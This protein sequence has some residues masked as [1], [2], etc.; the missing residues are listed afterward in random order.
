MLRASSV[1]IA[2]SP[3]I[4]GR[5]VSS[6]SV[7]WE[8]G[9]V[10]GRNSLD[11]L[12]LSI[13]NYLFRIGDSNWQQ[14]GLTVSQS[15]L[16]GCRH[17]SE[18]FCIT[19]PLSRNEIPPSNV[20]QPTHEQVEAN[21][22][23][24]TRVDKVFTSGDNLPSAILTLVGNGNF[25]TLD[26]K[27]RCRK[28]AHE[29]CFWQSGCRVRLISAGASDWGPNRFELINIVKP[30]EGNVPFYVCICLRV[31]VRIYVCMYALICHGATDD[32]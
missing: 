26:G 30:R 29:S 28:M 4:A 16:L 3:S 9:G 25:F 17:L 31:C 12:T 24:P 14:P 22:T 18:K 27:L 23:H 21:V 19:W 32:L 15:A 5:I 13:S 1:V 10:R 7:N 2:R 8:S 6:I 11:S 20:K